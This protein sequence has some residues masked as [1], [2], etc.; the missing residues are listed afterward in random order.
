MCV[1]QAAHLYKLKGIERDAMS[2][3]RSNLKESISKYD[4]HIG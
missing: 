1:Y 2:F 3:S 4:L